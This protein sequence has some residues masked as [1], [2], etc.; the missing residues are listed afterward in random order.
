MDAITVACIFFLTML[1]WIGT[2]VAMLYAYDKL[3]A[4]FRNRRNAR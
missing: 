4:L 3:T 1:I 2:A